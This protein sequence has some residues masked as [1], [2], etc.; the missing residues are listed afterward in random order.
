[1]VRTGRFQRFVWLFLAVMALLPLSLQA[2]AGGKG[3]G[4]GLD[5][6]LSPYFLIPG[7][8]GGTEQLPLK[9]T[10]ADV[11]I[12]GVIAGVKVTQVYRNEGDHPIE[13][14]Y[15][16]PGSTRA[17]V[18][19]MR[20]VIGKRVIEAQIQKKEKAREIYTKAKEEGKRAS[21]LEQKR[22]NVFQMNVANIMPGDTVQVELEYTETL[23]PEEGVYEFVYPAV[24]G[25]RYS[26]TPDSPEHEEERW[27]QNPYLT[28]GSKTPYAFDISVSLSAGMPL[29]GVVSPSH[30]VNISYEDKTSAKVRLDAGE[31]SG[32]N[33]DFILRYSLQ[34]ARVESGLLLY[35]GE[36]EN[37]FLLTVEPP[38]RP[39]SAELPPREYLFVLDVSGSMYDF[40]LDTAKTLIKGL[41]SGLKPSD[42]FNVLLFAGDSKVLNERP[43]PAS[44]ENIRSALT[45]IEEQRGGGGTEILPALNRALGMPMSENYSRSV[46]VITD[47]YVNVEKETFDVIRKNLG[48]ANLFAFGIGSSV[49]RFL[50]EG[51]ARAGTGEHFVV[52]NASDASRE[53]ERFR[54]YIASPVL[55]NIKID[56]GGFDVYAMDPPSVPDLFAQRPITIIGKWRGDAP[57]GT[58][59]VTGMNGNG[60]LVKRIES[61]AVRSGKELA[62]LMYLWARHRIATLGDYEGLGHSD[63]RKQEITSLGLT[64]HLL[65][66]FTSFVAVD[67]K[68]TPNPGGNAKTV[69][70]P[71]P[72]PQGVSNYAVGG[73]VPSTPE[74]ETWLMIAVVIGIFT[75]FFFKNRLVF[76]G[77]RR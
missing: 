28:E 7:G 2:G 24:V 31:S 67:R 73:N 18:H 16:F 1:M 48:K 37:F 69:K 44:A 54:R 43:V 21:L 65:T 60:K 14:V 19:A 62:P 68:E 76:A 20:M 75:W 23:S 3:D 27:V 55:T 52:T 74:P 40:P 71:L 38:K 47:G 33:R 64:Y 58:I 77:I 66:E 50:I 41:L 36:K 12:A 39:E 46:V 4:E 13:A 34:G 8:E 29:S 57:K 70:Q 63:E 61:D 35:K 22:P 15:V 32:G 59:K 42:Q 49:N 10:S 26:R 17:A 11:A 45:L 53:A 25:P 9:K 30:K 5:K 51:M 6:T 56:F 72:L